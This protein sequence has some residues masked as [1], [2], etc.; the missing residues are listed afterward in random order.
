MLRINILCGGSLPTTVKF[1]LGFMCS[2]AILDLH[3]L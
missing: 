3:E 2:N 1:D